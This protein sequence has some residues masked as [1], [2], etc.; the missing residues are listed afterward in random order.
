LKRS[1]AE[2]PADQI[3]SLIEVMATNPS[4][5]GEDTLTEL[6][7]ILGRRDGSGVTSC[8]KSIESPRWP[9]PRAI[10]RRHQERG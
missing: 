9:A 2:L 8:V 6:A 1:L 5:L 7:S 10:W 4:M 3:K